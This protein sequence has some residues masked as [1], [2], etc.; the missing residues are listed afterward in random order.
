MRGYSAR[1]D[2]TAVGSSVGLTV[3]A[4]RGLVTRHSAADLHRA[5]IRTGPIGYR[6]TR[7]ARPIGFG[8]VLAGWSIMFLPV[9]TNQGGFHQVCGTSWQ[10]MFSSRNNTE[11]ECGEAAVP[12]LWIAGAV[13]AVGVGIALWSG[14]R[15]RLLAMVGLALLLTLLINAAGLVAAGGMGGA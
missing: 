4:A 8:I 7:L 15:G 2:G 9:S 11:Y 13:F 6:V 3:A 1:S 14:S 12:H 5:K 10:A